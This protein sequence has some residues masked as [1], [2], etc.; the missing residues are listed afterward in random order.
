MLFLDS[1]RSGPQFL[2]PTLLSWPWTRLFIGEGQI[3]S[4]H[5]NLSECF[6]PPPPGFCS[7]WFTLS[8]GS[9]IESQHAS[10]ESARNVSAVCSLFCL[11]FI[12]CTE[13]L[14]Q[15]Q[16]SQHLHTDSYVI[17]T[18]SKIDDSQNHVQVIYN[19]NN[20]YRNTVN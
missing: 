10:L 20:S 16:S 7:D 18:C 12:Y 19:H 15:H 4:T 17:F 3:R 11:C 9:H 6:P 8:Y 14:E 13:H 1:Y 2:S 5:C